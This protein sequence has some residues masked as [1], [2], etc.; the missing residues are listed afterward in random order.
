M[1]F[2]GHEE[3]AVPHPVANHE[4][5]TPSAQDDA[6][7]LKEKDSGHGEEE[8]E[9][10]SRVP[11][12]MPLPA[13]PADAKRDSEEDDGDDEFRQE[14]ADR[15]RTATGHGDTD[16]SEERHR[17]QEGGDPPERIGE[18]AQEH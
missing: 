1:S 10:A 12:R 14:P 7:T 15:N 17:R 5:L 2:R 6:V 3:F 11:E 16:L 8:K 9:A 18:R 4:I 13:V